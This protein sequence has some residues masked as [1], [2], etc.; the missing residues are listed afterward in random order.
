MLILGAGRNQSSSEGG[1]GG[2][3]VGSD[4]LTAG[5]ALRSCRKTSSN[6]T[7]ASSCSV[8]SGFGDRAVS[9]LDDLDGIEI[10]PEMIQ[11]GIDVLPESGDFYYEPSIVREVYIAMAR[12]RQTRAES[13][14]LVV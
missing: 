4:G 9:E 12:A 1:T 5:L 3:G 6:G 7:A 10:T 8:R 2:A 11:A 13:S 14:I